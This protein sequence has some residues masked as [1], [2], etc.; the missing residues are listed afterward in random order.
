MK[1]LHLEDNACD[2]ELIH[3]AFR[4][5]WP[6]CTIEV[7][8][9]RDD[10]TARLL[11][12]GH[13]LIVSDFKLVNFDGLAA[14]KL[15]REKQP[16][17]PFV[18][19]SGTIGEDRAI[20]ALRSGAS[21]YVLK[22]RPKRLI[23]A[24][25]QA[26]ENAR[27]VRERQ[28]AE[29][30]LLRV[31]RLENIG[32]L[33]AGIAHD[34][35]NVLAPVLM[36]VSLLRDRLTAANEQ[37]LLSSI[38]KSV[39][40]GTGLIR[41]ILGFAHGVTGEP[42]LMQPKHLLRELTDVMHQ[43]FPKE[44][45]IES[46]IETNLWPLRINPTQLHQVLLNLCVNA[47]DAM[48]RGG[49]LHLCGS[50][51]ELDDVSAAAIAGTRPGSYVVFEV[52]DTGTGIPPEILAR[53]WEPFFT[54]KEAGRGTGLG[55]PTV[56]GIVESYGGVI[57]LHSRLG[58]GTTFQIFLPASPGNELLN[59][60]T[61]GAAIPLGHG[62]LVIVVD[63]D[64]NVRDVTSAMLVRHGYRVLAAANGTEA[65]ALFAARSLEVRVVVTDVSMPH[66]D[67]VALARIVR[68]LNPAT[69]LLAMSGL[70]DAAE[71]LRTH[72]FPGAFLHKPFTAET[73]LRTIHEL[74]TVP[75]ISGNN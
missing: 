54:T 7:V 49:T 10:Y 20:E 31:Q 57:S 36:A 46:R 56:R 6:D 62:E 68:N 19:L 69:R 60:A 37:K 25:R 2:A 48:P 44:I 14:L 22:D 23:P 28:A 43:T 73:L 58:H 3:G 5:E 53:I 72:E 4:A 63:D 38:E 70:P 17:T 71:R 8:A 12:G 65:V 75:A 52:I 39:E 55:L 21:D 66:L 33:A 18:F 42:Q 13:D 11:A 61:P 30:Q 40:R 16:A 29:E 64:D 45:Q 32:M 59:T 34:F 41:Q 15:A 26:L 1:I 35:N 27:Q 24:V 74:L 9:S 67:G 51:R 50:N 47:R